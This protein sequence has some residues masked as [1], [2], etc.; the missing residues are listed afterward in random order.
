V[1]AVSA[2]SVTP[3]KGTRLLAVDSI[4]LG[5]DGADGNRRFFLVDERGRMVNAKTVGSLQAV[6]ADYVDRVGRLMMTFPDGQVVGGKVAHGGTIPTQFF[7]RAREARLVQ[8]PWSE[9]I[10]NLAGRRLRLVEANGDGAAVDRGRIG[11]A[12]LIS[13]A[14][15][16]RLAGEAGTWSVD[17]R[18]FRM[19][20]EVDGT[21]AHEEDRWVGRTTRVGEAT[22]AWCGHVGRC[23][24]TSRDPDSGTVDLPTLDIL[25][26]YRDQVRDASGAPCPP[27]EPVPFGIFGEV[28]EGGVVRVGD[29]VA[30]L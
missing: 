6:V 4:S 3:V 12:T 22:I 7:S 17:P 24:I 14:S 8:G 30:V 13:R 25:R 10:S 29:E 23:L 5:P 27:T 26:G 19:L 2:L 20:I 16:D 28:V 21:P 15:L 11:A 9:A 1:I 18:R